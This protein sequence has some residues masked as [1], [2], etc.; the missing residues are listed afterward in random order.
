MGNSFDFSFFE[1][2]VTPTLLF[3]TRCNK[4]SGSSSEIARLFK[5]YIQIQ[6]SSGFYILKSS[7]KA[8]SKDTPI[9]G[10]EEIT[11]NNYR[12]MGYSKLNFMELIASIIAYSLTSWQ[13][14]VKL[15]FLAFDFD[16]SKS[17]TK[18]EMMI[19]II[20]FLK[21]ISII[22]C[23]ST[24]KDI[25]IDIL[26]KSCFQAADINPDGI[27]TLDELTH[28]VER[29]PII[30]KLFMKTE[31]HKK[32]LV[33]GYYPKIKPNNKSSSFNT[34]KLNRRESISINFTGRRIFT[35][36]YSRSRSK[37]KSL[38]KYDK[39]VLNLAELKEIFNKSANKLG[40]TTVIKLYE[41]LSENSHYA[42]DIDFLFHEFNFDKNKEI[43]FSQFLEY[44]KKKRSKIGYTIDRNG[45]TM[46]P[47]AIT[48]NKNI[49]VDV[50][51]A[52]LKTMFTKFDKNHDGILSIDELVNGLKKDFNTPTIKEMFNT[53]D[54]DKNNVL[55][56]DE[57]ID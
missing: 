34:T 36:S 49:V 22:T 37:G 15:S 48:K 19:M 39:S 38:K 14:K 51:P 47:E 25:D 56:F 28:W 45:E 6:D 2:Q 57:F 43:N 33:Y 11:Y 31:I 12:I 16:E 3:L 30:M 53:Y 52:V 29:S 7:L 18:D 42:E 41:A 40:Y 24:N 26:T 55:D 32:K 50:N 5:N 9:K 44:M 46:Y 10:N 13:T 8:I 27:I 1:K 20:S 54:K 4:H 17:I 21:G 23:T 35:N